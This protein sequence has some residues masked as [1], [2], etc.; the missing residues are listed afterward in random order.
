[1]LEKHNFHWRDGFF[2]GFPKK[3]ALFNTLTGEIT[4]KQI[5]SIT[6][7]R[8]TGKTT[9]L[10]Q[11]IDHIIASGKTKREH[12]L[13]YTFDE[14]QPKIEELFQEY[15][16]RLGKGI[17][18]SKD[19]IYVF[20]DEVQKLPN[21][22]N[23]VKYYYDIDYNIKFFVSGSAS[24]FIKKHIRESLAGRI[25]EYRLKNLSFREY[26]SFKGKEELIEKQDLLKD[27]LQ[28]EFLIYLGRQFIETL[29]EN[30]EK[31]RQYTRTI[32]DKIVHQ[33]IPQTFPIEYEGLLMNLLKIIASNPGMLTDYKS[34]SKD[35]GI[36]RV[37]LSNYIYYLEESFLV[38]KL[39]N[40][41]TN[42][43]TS[44]KKMK[45]LYAPMP[46]VTCLSEGL[47]ESKIVENMLVDATDAT[48]F[49]RTPQ[50]Y[51]ID[52]ILEKDGELLPVEV[53]FR[54]ILD[55]KDLK[56]ILRFCDRFNSK[57]AIIVTKD[58]T[59]EEEL[60]TKKGKKVEVQYIPAWRYCLNIK[61]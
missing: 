10:K 25:A 57:K 26:L 14:E 56:N 39:Y 17:L 35:L 59:G 52:L 8:R 21:W 30:E 12:V 31:A 58:K 2:Y 7:L 33:D 6:G 9:L 4:S 46:V 47:A 41:S 36:S 20:L 37:T 24:L 38:K 49:W 54:A 28:K 44:E 22:Q 19:R 32:L 15:E 23:Q 34:L 1:M 27:A 53:K 18:E 48:F 5:V 3:R 51:E 42:R 45:K 11:L 29:D 43:L 16:S 50:K 40:F 60:Q 13:L 61:P 55:R